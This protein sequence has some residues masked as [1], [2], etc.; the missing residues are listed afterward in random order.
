[1]AAWTSPN[2]RSSTCSS[3]SCARSSRLRATASITSKPFGV[4]ATCCVI[5]RR[6]LSPDPVTREGLKRA[7]ATA[8]FSLLRARALAHC[9]AGGLAPGLHVYAG[10]IRH[11]FEILRKAHHRFGGSQHQIPIGG[12]RVREPAENVLLGLRVEIH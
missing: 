9:G 12:E 5:P 4:A 3:A 7:R 2:S 6:R 1:M 8:P 10:R 11:R